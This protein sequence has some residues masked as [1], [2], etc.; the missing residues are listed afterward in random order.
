M[1]RS[2][3]KLCRRIFTVRADV[4]APPLSWSSPFR[5]LSRKALHIDRIP[6]MSEC[7][8]RRLSGRPTCF[9]MVCGSLP[10]VASA[11]RL[12]DSGSR[13]MSVSESPIALR[14]ARLNSS[15]VVAPAFPSCMRTGDLSMRSHG[16]RFIW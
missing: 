11:S 12:V 7:S 16:E 4:D 14:S 8:L 2:M 3:P 6:S 13:A 1:R 9:C 15:D 5:T 10:P